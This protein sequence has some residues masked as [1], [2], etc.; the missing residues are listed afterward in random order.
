MTVLLRSLCV[1]CI[2]AGLCAADGPLPGQ[3]NK[4]E[5][6]GNLPKAIDESS[7][8]VKSRR[9]PDRDVFWT[10]NDSGD[11]ARIFAIDSTGKLLRE[12]AIPHAENVD[13]EEIS[14]DEQGRLL[15]CDIGDNNRDNNGGKRDGVTLY[16]LPEPDAFDPAE[17]IPDPDVF[18]FRYPQGEG[19]FD[20][21]GVFVR[22]GAAYLFNKL[23]EGET[24]LYRLPLPATA[25]AEIVRMS[26]V[27]RTKSFNVVTGAA[28]SDDGRHLALINYLCVLVLDLP[29]PFEELQ[30][31]AQ[32]LLPLFSAPRRVLNCFLGQTEGVT[33][34]G[35]DLVLT[36]EG[37]SIFRLKKAR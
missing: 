7:G 24:S 8:I 22:R 34:D 19:P 35:P 13:W 21:E 15:V 16:R 12:V 36:T 3:L 20:A 33:W 28:L 1:C 17:K 29:V 27:A 4:A 9:Y 37:S 31:D 6:K 23:L 18:R 11:T 14:M 5:F 26:V 32:G 30:P 25:P 10:H 2:A